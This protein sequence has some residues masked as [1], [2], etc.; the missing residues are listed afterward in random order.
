MFSGDLERNKFCAAKQT[1]SMEGK[2]LVEARAVAEL[3]WPVSR[4]AEP[5]VY[6]GIMPADFPACSMINNYTTL[7]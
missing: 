3:C 2:R 4:Q 5:S 6:A 1:T 7:L